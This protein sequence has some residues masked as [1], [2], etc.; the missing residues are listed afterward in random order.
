MTLRSAW[1]TLWAWIG[2]WR[3]PCSPTPLVVQARSCT[4]SFRP[5]SG[6]TK[7]SGISPRSGGGT[8]GTGV[9]LVTDAPLWLRA[10]V[11]LRWPDCWI[12]REGG[13]GRN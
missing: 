7:R 8:G 11:F 2:R 3:R 9:T 1:R 4:I 10:H 5:E 12:R 6:S 13:W